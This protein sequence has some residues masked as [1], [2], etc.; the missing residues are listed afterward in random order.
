MSVNWIIFELNAHYCINIMGVYRKNCYLTDGL[1]QMSL[2][3]L[4]THLCI[5]HNACYIK[6]KRTLY[7]NEN[8][9]EKPT[10]LSKQKINNLYLHVLVTK[11]KK[12]WWHICFT[13][14]EII[15]IILLKLTWL[16]FINK[17]IFTMCYN[18][19]IMN[20]PCLEILLQ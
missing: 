11:N 8:Y 12:E 17:R 4:H 5:N 7:N 13:L 6:I 18:R 16:I 10:K 19:T 3:S 2:H 15:Y 20:G 14:F 1:S 9:I